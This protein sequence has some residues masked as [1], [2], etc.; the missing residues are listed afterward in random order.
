MKR[1]IAFLLGTLLILP[2]CGCSGK[3][4]D[5][6]TIH[7]GRLGV[8]ISLDMP[9]ETIDDLLGE[10][11]MQDFFYA[12]PDTDMEVI[13]K[14][15]K[16]VMLTASS[17]IWSYTNGIEADSTTSDVLAAFGESTADDGYIY[18]FDEQSDLISDKEKAVTTAIFADSDNDGRL[19]S[20]SI[21]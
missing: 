12:Y 17:G 9:K 18:L 13:Y 8:D 15:G 20:I 2:L 1:I 4:Q 3:P 14:E 21:T 16:A 7:N 5:A 11:V 6:R 19:N 10:P